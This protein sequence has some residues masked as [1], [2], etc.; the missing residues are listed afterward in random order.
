MMQR[1]YK[2]MKSLAYHEKQLDYNIKGLIAEIRQKKN[3][4]DDVPVD[5]D[6]PEYSDIIKSSPFNPVPIGGLAKTLGLDTGVL[7]VEKWRDL[8]NGWVPADLLPAQS[9]L[10]RQVVNT[11]RGKML[12]L[13]RSAVLIKEDGSYDY[14]S[15]DKNRR[16]GTEFLYTFGSNLSTVIGHMA[17]KDPSV[18]RRFNDL[19]MTVFRENIMP[20]LLKDAGIRKGKDG[21]E[22]HRVKEIIAVPFMHSEN[23]S[24]DPNYHFHFDLMNVA[25]GFDDRLYTL[26]TDQIGQ[27]ASKYDA[28][29]MSQMKTAL[30]REFGFRF[31]KVF[32]KDDVADDFQQDTDRKV[33]SFDLPDAV[34]PENVREHR[35]AREKE[36]ENELKRLKKSGY[37]AKEIARVETRDEKTDLSPSQLKALWK[38]DF[39]RMGWTHEQMLSD[40]EKVKASYKLDAPPDDLTLE[41][42]YLR[43]SKEVN[44]TEDQFKAHII[45]QLI[46]HMSTEQAERE[47]ERIF[48]SEAVMMMD[49]ERAE[50]FKPFL[51]DEITNP[52]EYQSMQIR[53]GREV[54]FTT[55]RIIAMDEYV[56][57]SLKEREHDRGFILDK[58]RVQRAIF[59]FESSK[60]FTLAPGQRDAIISA[61][62]APGAVLSIQGRAG[63]GKS[64]L[65]K[66]VK[67]QYQANGFDVWGTSTSSTATKGL[68]DSTG[69]EPERSLNAAKLIKQLDKGNLR[70]TN[71]SV[72]FV[73]EAGMMDTET[74]YSLVKH[75]N[76]AG[77]KLILT[78]EKEQLSP[79][80]FG[81]HFSTLNQRFTTAKVKDIN[82]QKE[83]AER[84]MVEDFASGRSR[85]G[86]KYLYE[87]GRVII[88]DTTKQRVAKLVDDYFASRHATKD[89][90]VIAATNDDVEAL[91]DAIR[92]RLK[93]QGKLSGPEVTVTGRDGLER[94]F[95][96]GDKVIITKN[97]KS[98]DLT[99][100]ELNNSDSAEV[101][102]FRK[103]LR[104]QITSFKLQMEDGKEVWMSATKEQ[105]I[106]HAYAVTVHKSQG[107]TV[108]EAFYFVS[109]NINSLNQ[110]YVACSRHQTRVSMYLSKDMLDTMVENMDSKAPTTQQLKVAQWVAQKSGIELPEEVRTSFAACRNFLNDKYEKIEGVA[111]SP[112][113]DFISVVESMSKAQFKKTTFDFEILD[114]KHRN[115]YEAA[116]LYQ[117][118]KDL[119]VSMKNQLKPK[120][121][122]SNIRPISGINI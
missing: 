78:G 11:G 22:L 17:T 113:D 32:H 84:E 6:S 20:E 18:E 47:A 53:Y 63:S 12:K 58:E 43:H 97:T 101:V 82:R 29:F 10:A 42:S 119:E 23:R 25:L 54:T 120:I 80:G 75:A 30:E 16:P 13:N 65:L 35:M 31:E 109:S 64:S 41:R 28:I 77:A 34:I 73:D 38:E 3:I 61:T 21:K 70:L 98:D 24:T 93:D 117:R 48:K 107:Q 81:G 27:N 9:H 83:Q 88:T 103:G 90:I 4:P 46:G 91:N 106:R 49:K 36:I 105:N 114:G 19:C 87:Q 115:T 66:V 99:Q 39:D 71:K 89:K 108:Q 102:E 59:D 76:E 7:T 116:R 96:L 79:V 37:T 110:A 33:V 92:A 57:N 52:A 1:R 50:F 86:V 14:K 85:Q 67:D 51:A 8:C 69:L 72:L 121:M 95:A 104:G 44:F 122:P 56:V 40:L 62:T 68:A 55:R 111:R 26:N 118:Q 2:A 15:I 100:T 45:K 60:G 94:E 5:L 74:Y 112:I